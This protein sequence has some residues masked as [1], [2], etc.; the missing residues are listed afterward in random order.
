M[1]NV[2]LSRMFR[3]KVRSNTCRIIILTSIVWL[4][5]DVVVLMHYV[6][7]F[8][9]NTGRRAGEYEVEISHAHASKQIAPAEDDDPIVDNNE[10]DT[11]NNLDSEWAIT[12][13]RTYRITE[14]KRW[15]SAP[16]VPSVYGRP[17]E[18]GK[19]VVIPREQ[20]ALMKEKFKENQFNLMA[21]DMISLNRSL[22]DVRN[23]D[24]KLRNYPTKL[25]TT[26]IVI[27]FHNE[28]WTTLLRTVWS[29]I[30]RSPRPLLKEIILVDDAS[31]RDYLGRKLENYVKTLPVK[32][33]VLRTEKRSGLI[34]ARLLGAKHVTGQII[35]FLDA[36]CECTEGWLEPLLTRIAKDRTTVVCPII[37]VISDDTFEYVTAS[38]QTWGG[39]NWKLNFRWYRVPQ[40]EME[41]RHNDKTAPLRSPTM[42]GGLFSID[43]D[44]FYEIG[45]YDEGMDIWGGENL[46]MSFR[47]WQCGGILEIIPCSHVGHVFRDKSPYTFPGGVAKIVLHNAARVAEVWLDQWK[48][49]YYAM[50]PGARKASAGD[51]SE[52]RA[53]RDRL[54]CKS[55]RWYL[56]N[57]Y[58]ESQ[59]PL[60]YYFLGE[61]Q[62]A[63]TQNCLDT[64][65]RK[66][67]EPIGSSYCH[68]LG[69]NQVFAYTKRH[70][71]MSDDNCLDAAHPRGPVKLVRCHGM[72]GNQEWK[73]DEE[74]KTIKH[75]NSGNCLTRAT[76]ED[77]S[78]P[79]LRPCDYS[80]G[81][82]W[83]MKTQFK[84]QAN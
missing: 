23:P 56:E 42:A 71:I 68:G 20:Q 37:D 84:W 80:E 45:S 32:T 8:S 11:N 66:A 10:I 38:D 58:P 15:R 82:Q 59:M 77:P 64:M 55:F 76:S 61:I 29:V 6:D 53:L 34:R 5:I 17:G 62:N 51:V 31:E 83:L 14:L 28:A 12:I 57:I 1:T 2:T 44:F 7:L 63:E 19:P 18:M 78:T 9:S 13:P 22:S 69:G 50:S 26:S 3:G 33:F 60:D 43:K 24:C 73:Y 48:E 65:G 75:I 46:E 40:R 47:I 36:H 67:N 27:V 35:T 54:K 4:L 79:L 16:I 49:F 70:Q 30:N 39:F 74:E 41:R 25:P 21:S 81:Q 72:Q 52:R